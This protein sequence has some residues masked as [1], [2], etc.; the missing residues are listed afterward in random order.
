MRPLRPHLLTAPL[1][2]ALLSGC[3]RSTDNFTPRI[4]ISG[5]EGGALAQSAETSV[6][7]YALDDVGVTEIQVDGQ[8]VPIEPGSR[9][10]ANFKFQPQPQGGKAQHVII[11]RDAAG[12][13]GKATVTVMVDATK[14]QIQITSYTRVR[15][16]IR[17]SGVA[18]DNNRVTQ[19]LVDGNRLNITPGPRVEFYAETSGVYADLE[20]I[21]AA[22]NVTKRRAQ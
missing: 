7:G 1:A 5:S 12:H 4:V 3:A 14:P 8:R 20:V 16:V 22:G 15:S 2:L 13:E 18:T 9:K 10:I 17:L 6:R 19:I 21:D 11:A